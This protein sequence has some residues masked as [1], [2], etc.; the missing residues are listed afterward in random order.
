MDKSCNLGDQDGCAR[1]ALLYA[2]GNGVKPDYNLAR[3]ISG[4]SCNHGNALG[5]RVNGEI[6]ALGI[7][8]RS[9]FEEA[10]RAWHLGCEKG[11]ARACFQAGE[12]VEQ[13]RGIEEDKQAAAVLYRR[14]IEIATAKCGE[15]DPEACVDLA[16]PYLYGLGVKAN[17]PRASQRL[18]QACSFNIAEAC[19]ALGDLYAAGWGIQADPNR[20]VELVSKGCLGGDFVGCLMFGSLTGDPVK[21]AQVAEAEC[22]KRGPRACA[23]IA[24]QY[25]EGYGVPK[26]IKLATS[27]ARASCEAGAGDGCVLLA[28]LMPSDPSSEEWL[29]RGYDLGN[30]NA[31]IALAKRAHARGD[32]A[33]ANRLNSA[34]CAMSGRVYACAL[35]ADSYFESTGGVP[36]NPQEGRR[37]LEDACKIPDPL[38]CM[39]LARRLRD[40]NG[41][42][43]DPAKAQEI[44]ETTCDT[45]WAAA[46]VE[47][48]IMLETG[49]GG[50]QDPVRASELRAK[51]C[52]NDLS[53]IEQLSK[54]YPVGGKTLSAR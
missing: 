39:N 10:S 35:N 41:L 49:A 3:S 40:G 47:A 48:A 7:R 21:L 19:A 33:S 30:V 27:Q 51:A 25:A 9:D 14:G 6:L 34:A 36:A 23:N 45:P 28:T 31:A 22:R 13:G 46:C 44:F 17:F 32:L 12:Q 42:S 8:G 5:C 11:D 29:R 53:C 1:L 24:A 15:S 38:A 2:W 54:D 16:M 43:P 50:A 26:N 52:W 20:A 37:I 4:D 18:N